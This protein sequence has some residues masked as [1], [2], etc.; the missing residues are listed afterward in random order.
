M[1]LWEGVMKVLFCLLLV[2]CCV[3]SRPLLF[4]WNVGK[5]FY[6]PLISYFASI[7]FAPQPV[8][9]TSGTVS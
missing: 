9:T 1:V 3:E 4:E 5:W 2:N 7:Q 8:S 6:L